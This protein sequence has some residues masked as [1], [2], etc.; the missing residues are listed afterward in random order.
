[1]MTIIWTQ[2]AIDDISENVAY[3]E[4]KWTK[5]EV[6]SFL[7]KVHNVLEKL[8]EGNILFKPTEYKNIFQIVIVKQVTLFYEIEG[9]EL[10]LLRFWNNYQ[11]PEQL[12]F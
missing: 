4:K 12:S 7:K 10:Y 5:K 3:L 6:A 8:S 11:D 1:M 9:E 2:A